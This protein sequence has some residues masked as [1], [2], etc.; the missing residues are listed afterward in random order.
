MEFKHHW[1]HLTGELP[2]T[3]QDLI[4]LAT[5]ESFVRPTAFARVTAAP[6]AKVPTV[7]AEV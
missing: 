5:S 4:R 6:G 2:E 7:D 3:R 1:L